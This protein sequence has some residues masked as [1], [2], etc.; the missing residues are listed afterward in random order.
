MKFHPV[1]KDAAMPKTKTTA[2]E[3][4]QPNPVNH[5][6]GPHIVDGNC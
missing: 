3:T 6:N 2:D 5:P 1:E 4:Q